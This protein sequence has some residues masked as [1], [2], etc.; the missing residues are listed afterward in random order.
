MIIMQYQLLCERIISCRDDED[1]TISRI[2]RVG[3]VFDLPAGYE[4]GPGAQLVRRRVIKENGRLANV[5]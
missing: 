5:G 2:V 3:A 1:K 4:P